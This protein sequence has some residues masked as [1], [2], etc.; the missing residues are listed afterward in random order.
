[1]NRRDFLKKTF[2]MGLGLGYTFLPSSLKTSW[3]SEAVHKGTPFPDLVAVKGGEP[4]E[5]FD[6]AMSFYGGMERFISKGDIVAVKPNVSW[7]LSPER[8]G[9]TNPLLVARV[10]RRCIEAGA[11]KVYVFDH[12]CSN[13]QTCYSMSGIEEAVRG[14]GGIMVPSNRS[15]YYV[16][17]DI[18]KGK[19]LKNVLVHEVLMEAHFFINI[20]VLKHHS[21]TGLSIAMKNLMGVVWD[22]QAYH[23]KGL[24][25]CIAD[26]CLFREPDLNIVDAYR[27]I[28]RNGPRGRSVEDV[29]SMKNLIISSDIVAVDT[30]A[31]MVY[32]MDPEKVKYIRYAYENNLGNMDLSDLTIKKIIM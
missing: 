11:R 14:A 18:P 13:W 21:S 2:A 19:I 8:A 6:R 27:V 12:T 25:Q 3:G 31:S 29:V 23:L 15:Q 16:N 22:R 24:N 32:G 5:M 28:T 20:P 26:F 1:M 4:G 7:D 9:N 17:V 10:V 30:A